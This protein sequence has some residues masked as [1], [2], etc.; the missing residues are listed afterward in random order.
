MRFSDRLNILYAQSGV[1]DPKTAIRKLAERLISDCGRSEPPFSPEEY[2]K[3]RKIKVHKVRLEG[4]NA[5][6]IPVQGGYIAEVD[7]H[8][9]EGRQNFSIG[10]EI[11]HTFFM[12]S[13]DNTVH[14]ELSCSASLSYEASTEEFLCDLTAAE[15][16]MPERPFRLVASD[17]PLKLESIREISSIFNASALATT[18]RIIELNVK[19]CLLVCLQPVARERFE[20]CFEVKWWQ[21]SSSAFRGYLHIGAVLS[22]LKQALQSPDGI[23]PL[24]IIET[25]RTG[26][27]TEGEL[28]FDN[29]KKSL[30]V[31]S[32]VYGRQKPLIFSLISKREPERTSSSCF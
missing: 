6:L 12:S 31:Q 28:Y 2:C 30:D 5:R 15:L 25:A 24:G 32:Y 4:C 9:K 22:C 1:R 29:L 13:S 17:F 20:L 11:G 26:K 18:K 3:L 16:L 14:S 21:A 10:H 27:P 19:Q 8:Q 7:I 23:K